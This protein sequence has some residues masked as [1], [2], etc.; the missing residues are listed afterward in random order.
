MNYAT[1]LKAPATYPTPAG[2][3]RL[4]L[5]LTMMIAGLYFGLFVGGQGHGL[6]L[7]S[8]LVSPFVILTDKHK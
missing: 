7:L 4:I 8:F 2:K 6:G 1:E 3:I 5:G